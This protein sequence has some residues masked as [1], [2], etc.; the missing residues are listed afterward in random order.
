MISIANKGDILVFK[1]GQECMVVENKI[2]QGS[3]NEK[4]EYH[5]W[6]DSRWI[7]VNLATG[8]VVL[9]YRY[10]IRYEDGMPYIPM[11]GGVTKVKKKGSEEIIRLSEN[12]IK[13]EF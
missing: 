7:L 13:H 2:S 12:K 9:H 11:W 8:S 6:D 1:D 3:Y 4:G 5:S 10:N